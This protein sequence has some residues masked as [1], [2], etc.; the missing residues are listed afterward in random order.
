MRHA[1]LNG[2]HEDHI[3][4]SKI[5]ALLAA[6]LVEIEDDGKPDLD[7]LEDIMSYV[8]VYPDAHHHPTEDIV[9]AQLEK[10]VPE[11]SAEIRDLLA[12]HADL[13]GKGR[14]FLDL[15]RAIEEEA[16]V[17]RTEL[18]SKGRS[19]LDRLTSHMNKEEARLFRL[20][21]ERLDQADWAAIGRRVEAMEDPL[22]GLAVS[23]DFRRLWQRISAHAQN[24]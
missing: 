19:Y 24:R 21:A 6:E 22:F 12:E 14:A 20:A 2:L 1:I 10:V 3:N 4:M 7:L 16:V 9:F 8:T 11:A 13:I 17:T 5:A 23:V 18:L 15:V